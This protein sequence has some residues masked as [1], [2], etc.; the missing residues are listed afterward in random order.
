M[1]HKYLSV[2]I[3]FSFF[4]F[5]VALQAQN[6]QFKGFGNVNYHFMND[7]KGKVN[8]HFE[9]GEFD[10][11]VT[12]QIND[13]ISFL[14]EVVISNYEAREF[15]PD[16]ERMIL[17]YK[18]SNMFS[19]AMG[20]FH[21]PV[22]YWNN[23]FNHGLA[24]Q[25][26]TIRP[27]I[28]GF[29]DEG[30]GY[31]PIHQTGIQFEGKN[32]T[33]VNFGYTVLLSNGINATPSLDF[34]NG[35]AITA[36]I[37]AEPVEN[38]QVSVSLMHDRFEKGTRNMQ[39][40][41][42]L[43]K[44]TYTLT[45]AGASYFKGTLPVEA[46]LEFYHINVQGDSLENQVNGGFL[47]AGYKMRKLVPFILFDFLGMNKEVSFFNYNQNMLFKVGAK[48]NFNALACIKLEVGHRESQV[49]KGTNL[50]DFQFAIGF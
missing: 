41:P 40:N 13:K 39:E 38:M 45:G 25:P 27:Q 2:F 14:S 11:F 22:G 26:T 49:D 12:S 31:L 16:V 42:V 29:E 50:I 34:N 36:K 7:S 20:K 8:N 24:L 19:V 35:K 6:T 47:Y 37:F 33:P 43:Y 5:P 17:K 15:A 3:L 4:L 23:A 21:I 32:I 10:L 9:L 48:Y 44:G 28:I 46:S 1:K 30:G 18:V